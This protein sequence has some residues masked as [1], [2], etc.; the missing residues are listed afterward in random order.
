MS[1]KRVNG[2]YASHEEYINY[3]RQY[4]KKNKERI[5][6]RKKND[7]W[8][9]KLKSAKKRADEAGVHFNIDRDYLNSIRVTHCPA[10]GIELKYTE[11]SRIYDDSATLD[12]IIPKLGYVKGNVQILSYK[13]N[14]MKSNATSDELVAFA[15]WVLGNQF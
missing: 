14:R 8:N 4:Y 9:D 12:R 1:K 3:H 13:A 11:N 5:A 15:N 2:G 7:P 6:L 10:L